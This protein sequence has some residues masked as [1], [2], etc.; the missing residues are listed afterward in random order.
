MSND[1]QAEHAGSSGTAGLRH[2]VVDAACR[3]M[4][5]ILT[6]SNFG[7]VATMTAIA[8]ALLG[9]VRSISSARLSD[10]WEDLRGRLRQ[11]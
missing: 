3:L 9:L 5:I 2:S 4:P 8:V 7:L 10:R 11:R 1:D 6:W